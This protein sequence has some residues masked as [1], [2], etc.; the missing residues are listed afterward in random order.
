MATQ[1]HIEIVGEKQEDAE[2]AAEL[3]FRRIDELELILSRFVPDSDISRINRMESGD[4]LMLDH[5][6][7]QILKHSV[8]ISFTM[9]I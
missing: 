2:N 3:C 8:E 6:T 4:E 7:W 9:I 5:E 1:F